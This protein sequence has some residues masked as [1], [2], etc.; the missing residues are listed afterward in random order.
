MFRHQGTS[1]NDVGASRMSLDEVIPHRPVSRVYSERNENSELSLA[2]VCKRATDGCAVPPLGI[3]V[4]A[5]SLSPYRSGVAEPYRTR[6]LAL[7][8]FPT[9]YFPLALSGPGELD[10]LAVISLNCGHLRWLF[11]PCV[12]WRTVSRHSAFQ[13]GR[14]TMIERIRCS[15]RWSASA[16]NDRQLL[17]PPHPFATSSLGFP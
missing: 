8:A 14:G 3:E 4:Q 6:F 16:R 12:T 2:S 15:Q 9:C 17:S 5:V 10:R 13:F 7:P 11:L 1:E